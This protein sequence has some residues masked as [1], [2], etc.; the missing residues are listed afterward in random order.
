MWNRIKKSIAENE[1][2]DKRKKSL[3]LKV[4]EVNDKS[5]DKDY[6]S[7]KDEDIDIMFQKFKELLSREK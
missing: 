4:I 3:E 5:K 6:Q 2:G 1:K 7:K